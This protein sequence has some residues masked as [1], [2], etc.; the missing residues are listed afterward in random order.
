[1]WIG[2]RFIATPEARAVAGY[3]D[4]LLK[5]AEDGTTISRA[6]SGKTMRVVANSYTDW[7]DHH[8]DELQGFPEQMG[9]SSRDGALHL[10]GDLDTGA[11]DPDKECYPSGQGVGAI[12]ELLPAGDVVRKLVAEADDALARLGSLRA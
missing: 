1:V 10:G 11:V 3:K 4:A 6:Y 9:R 8:P 2:T 7:W 12:D 5:T